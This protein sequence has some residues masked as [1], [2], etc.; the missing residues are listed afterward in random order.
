M[1][2]DTR[3][4]RE[5][6][7]KLLLTARELLDKADTEKRSLTADEQTNEKKALKDADELRTKIAAAEHR[8]DIERDI[9]AAEMSQDRDN[10]NR[11]GED[12]QEETRLS[13]SW[14][15]PAYRSLFTRAMTVGTQAFNSDELRA[16]SAGTGTEGG[17]L[18]APEQ[19]V[20]ELIQNVTDATIMRG[21]CRVFP[22][23]QGTDSL[24]FP[25]LDNRMAAAAWTSE[26]GTPSTDSTLSLGK[27]ALRP[28]PLAKEIIVSKVLLRKTAM[29]EQIVREELARVVAEAM[30]NGYMTGTGDQQ[31]LGVFT[32]S[33]NGVTTARDVSTGNTSSTPTFEGLKSAKYELKASYWPRAKWIFHRDIM[34][35]IAKLKDGNGRYMLQDSVQQAEPD[36]MLGAP[37]LLS[38]FAPNTVTTGLYVGILGDFSQYWIVDSLDVEVL[39]LE[40]LYARNNK[41]CFL[42]RMMSDGAPVRAEAFVRVKLG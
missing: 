13:R 40:E 6:R 30:E 10:E 20:S 16:L 23:I 39:R 3:E 24:G 36:R 18:Y 15:V 37:V 4:M 35:L 26:L 21:I 25:V 42:A 32:A 8:N 41:D 11:N 7:H 5:Q 17:Y 12:R 2:I 27:R 1:P 29:A 38:E 33:A 22:P 34:E 9:A 14:E 31:P 28:N 19:F